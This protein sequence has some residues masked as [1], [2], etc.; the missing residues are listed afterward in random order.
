MV[1]CWWWRGDGVAVVPWHTARRRRRTPPE[2]Y[3][4]GAAAAAARPTLGLYICA[5]CARFRSGGAV[6]FV[7]WVYTTQGARAAHGAVRKR[8][9]TRARSLLYRLHVN[10]YYTRDSCNI[11]TPRSHCSLARTRARAPFDAYYT[12]H[13]EVEQ[14]R[15]RQHSRVRAC[16]LRVMPSQAATMTTTTTIRLISV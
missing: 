6:R 8:A 5:V 16:V 14:R 12:V 13:I 9:S 4:I 3:N 7:R 1:V 11:R 15:R 10:V 2:H